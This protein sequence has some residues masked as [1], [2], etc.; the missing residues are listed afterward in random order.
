[1][2][3]LLIILTVAFIA[4]VFFLAKVIVLRLEQKADEEAMESRALF[5][6]IIGAKDKAFAEKSKLEKEANQIFT[7]YEMTKDINRH[8]SETE[9]LNIF[10]RKLKDN[11]TIDD[12][13]LVEDLEEK[14]SQ[15]NI[16]EG[17]SVFVLKTKERRLGYL[18]YKGVPTK[19]QEKFAIL[20][21]QFALALRRIHLY[22]DIAT[23]AIT[24]GLTTL[25]TRRYFLERFDEEVK[26][27]ALR[28]IKLSFLMLDVDHFKMVNDQY[29]HL[30][31]DAVLKEIGQIIR[32][33]IREIDI[34]GRYGGEEFCVVLPDTDL[35]GA[36]LVAE[37]IRR[38]AQDTLIRAY[39]ASIRV[40]VS[41]GISCYPTDGKL[42]EELIDKADWALY[43]AKSQ[44]RNA[45]VAF[46]LYNHS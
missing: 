21:H 35:E 28:K 32:E 1:M 45:V 16:P 17:H 2:N 19:D 25:Y 38:S 7:L 29:G 31:G 8:F 43:R 15:F 27:A 37:R 41:I 6:K 46:G 42:L 5:Q 34:A 4:M 39:D 20:A 13:Q 14:E 30:T 10:K 23:M 12:C 3:P 22:K 26:R 18:V 9:A 33:S 44:G 40:T 11:I 24:D 36:R